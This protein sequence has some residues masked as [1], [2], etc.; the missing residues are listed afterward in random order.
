MAGA[1]WGGLGRLAAKLGRGH[2]LEA[3]A[4]TGGAPRLQC[5]TAWPAPLVPTAASADAP[6][7]LPQG[8]TEII[9]ATEVHGDRVYTASADKTVRVWDLNTK[10]CVQVRGAGG[11]RE[12]VLGVQGCAI[13][14]LSRCLLCCFRRPCCLPA[15][16]CRRARLHPPP[17]ALAQVLE[18]H[19]R[20]VLSL[21]ICGNRLFSGSYDYSI[22]VWNLDTLQVQ[23]AGGQGRAAVQLGSGKPA[24]AAPIS[25]QPTHLHAP[26]LPTHNPRPHRSAKRR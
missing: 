7:P 6:S 20:P 11:G 13:C 16:R 4:A 14:C 2:C 8:H 10:R 19:T 23:A 24:A 25:H 12:G 17:A 26:P 5:C 21:A 9:W 1:G 15:R 22:R 18:S 3:V